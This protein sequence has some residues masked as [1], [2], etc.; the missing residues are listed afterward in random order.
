VKNLWPEKFE[1]NT[2]PSAKN[3]LE[4]QATYLSKLTGGIVYAEISELNG[5]DAVI[6]SL[7]NDFM[8][9]FDIRGKFMENYRF[10]VMMF[11]HDIALYPV[12][13]RLDEQLG[14]EFQL[15]QSA[16]NGYV[17]ECNDPE[18]VESLLTAV[19]NSERIRKVVGSL[20]KL[21]K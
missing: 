6:K 7:N 1:E 4:E 18:G 3:L 5:L 20:L 13:F 11:S 16:L 9:R 8:Y 12:K 15:P 17:T 21:S 2:Q 10:N 14:K 19:L